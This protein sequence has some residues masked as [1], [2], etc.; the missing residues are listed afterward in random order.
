MQDDVAAARETAR[1]VHSAWI[2]EVARL[3]ALAISPEEVSTRDDLDVTDDALY[4]TALSLE[5]LE[6]V[7]EWDQRGI[8]RLQ[9]L[10]KVLLVPLFEPHGAIAA[11]FE[12]EANPSNAFPKHALKRFVFAP[13]CGSLNLVSQ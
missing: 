11:T 8:C 3:T 7:L 4:E 6:R 5:R 12:R 9:M 1:A 10:E 2:A 13:L